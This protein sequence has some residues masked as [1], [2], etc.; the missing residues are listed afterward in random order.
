VFIA[1]RSAAKLHDAKQSEAIKRSCFVYKNAKPKKAQNIKFFKNTFWCVFS[2]HN[3]SLKKIQTFQIFL[4]KFYILNIEKKF[5][6]TKE[7][8]LFIKNSLK[9]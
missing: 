8:I 7:H 6:E 5:L 1:T 9:L 2:K 4:E 3:I